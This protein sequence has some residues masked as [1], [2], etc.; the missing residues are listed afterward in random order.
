MDSQA[1]HTASSGRSVAIIGAGAAGCFCAIE[2]RRKHPETNVIVFEAGPGPLAKL[3]ITGGG[4]C[5]ITNSFQFVRD[6]R[7]V[8]PRGANVI[9]RLFKAFG[10]ERTMQWWEQEGVRLV[11]M[12]DGCIFP[13]SQDAMQVVRALLRL[14]REEGAELHCGKKALQLCQNGSGWR[15]LFAD[16]TEY[17]CDKVV[18]TAGGTNSDRLVEMLPEGIAVTPTVPSLFTL[19]INDKSLTSLMGTVVE[20]AA[21]AIPGTGIRT[22]GALLITDWGI[23]G[24]ATLKLTSHAARQLND[25]AYRCPLLISWVDAPEQDVQQRLKS[26]ALRNGAKQIG[27]TAPEG[28][29]ERLW[30]HILHKSGIREDLR[31]AEC[32]SKTFN[33]LASI[34]TCDT[35]ETTGRAKFKEE[36]V[37]CGGISLESVNPSTLE[38]KN[39]PGL[40]FA[41]EV[42]DIDAVTGGFNL[43][44]AWT[45]AETV[46]TACRLL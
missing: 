7:D 4:R 35:Y 8:Y 46:A 37:T 3:A 28:L 16:G 29:T 21:V 26:E 43:Q 30:R 11:E 10:P 9:K 45:T 20:N 40:Y 5:N 17:D 19:K 41:G 1:S 31:L 24:P 42:L 22:N 14:M 6:L 44:A 25:K 13:E 33:R 34:L 36:F 23:S 12:E 39:F 15:I 32:G 38:S 27:N 2:L 18:L